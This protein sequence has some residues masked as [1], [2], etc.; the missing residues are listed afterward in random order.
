MNFIRMESLSLYCFKPDFFCSILCFQNLY[1]CIGDLFFFISVCCFIVS[2]FVYPFS[3]WKVGLFSIW[4]Y[5]EWSYC[6]HS[7]MSLW[8]TYSLISKTHP[9]DGDSVVLEPFF[10]ASPTLHALFLLQ[11]WLLVR[12]GNIYPRYRCQ[13]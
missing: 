7:D 2:K 6:E 9:R 4:I 1:C 13:T 12:F 8:E 5:E 11:F 3:Y 10:Q